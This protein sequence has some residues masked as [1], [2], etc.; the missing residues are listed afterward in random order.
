MPRCVENKCAL[1]SLGFNK[2]AR[3]LRPYSSSALYWFHGGFGGAI[4][5]DLA[6]LALQGVGVCRGFTMHSSQWYAVAPFSDG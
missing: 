5:A 4:V 2:F 1:L 6:R 3:R